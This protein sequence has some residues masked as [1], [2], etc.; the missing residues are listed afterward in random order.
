MRANSTQ[1]M[2]LLG[3]VKVAFELSVLFLV[4]RVVSQGA[5]PQP[6]IYL[7]APLLVDGI[8]IYFEQCESPKIYERRGSRASLGSKSPYTHLNP[9]NSPSVVHFGSGGF[10]GFSETT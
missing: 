2:G 5:E 7:V 8:K 3:R 1:E 9:P 10:S 4:Q 6:P